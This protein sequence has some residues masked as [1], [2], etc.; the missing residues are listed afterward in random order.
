M[1]GLSLRDPHRLMPL[2]GLFENHLEHAQF[3]VDEIRPCLLHA[4]ELVSAN[5]ADISVLEE[6]TTHELNQLLDRPY[7]ASDCVWPYIAAV[8]F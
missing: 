2:P 3:A 1:A 5:L 7:V 8:L 6:S 4:L